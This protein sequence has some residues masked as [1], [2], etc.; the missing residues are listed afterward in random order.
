MEV[1]TMA[2]VAIGMI[3]T[4][5]VPGVLLSLALFPRKKDLD[6]V[7]RLGVGAVLGLTPQFLLYFGDKNFYLPITTFTTTATVVLVS[8]LGLAVWQVRVKKVKGEKG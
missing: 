4:I 5:L 6:P 8:L 2:E 7:E 3:L 1:I